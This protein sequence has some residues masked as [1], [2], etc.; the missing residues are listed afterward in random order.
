MKQKTLTIIFG[1]ILLIGIVGAEPIL[2]NVNET[3]NLP[4][5]VVIA[6]NTF[7]GD[8]SFDYLSLP[9][10]DDNLPLI[11][12]L[13]VIS[14]N[15]S[16][17][18]EKDE[19]EVGGYVDKCTWTILG[20][21]VLPRTVYFNCSEIAP[22]TIEHE[23]GIETIDN[24]PDGTFYCYNE[25]TDLRLNEH[26][27]I[28]LNIKS[29]PALYPGIYNLNASLYYLTDTYAPIINIINKN[30]FDRYYRELDNIEIRVEINDINLESYWATIFTDENIGVPFSH[31]VYD[32]YYFTRNLPIDIPEGDYDLKVYAKDTEEN[33]AEDITTLKIDRTGPVITLVSPENN[34]VVLEIIPLKVNVSDEKSG[35]DPN[36][37]YYRLREIVNGQICP[38]IGVPLGN[39]SCT[40]TDWINLP[41]NSVGLYEEDINTTELNLNSGEYWLDVK[42]KDILGNEN[43]LQ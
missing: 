30:S 19:F 42:A 25:E 15:P 33:S 40:R 35:A 2:S 38:E 8:F 3:I 34:S 13:D 6:G 28:F 1:M 22:L 11:I 5:E 21:C 12:K 26:D 24:I 29:H 10:N 16:Y 9:D 36:E 17:P 7:Q 23:I 31:E 41:E 18:V 37:V 14:D 27:K 43:Y 39:Y 20:F 32:I 4:I